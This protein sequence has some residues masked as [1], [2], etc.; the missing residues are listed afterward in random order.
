MNKQFANLSATLPCQ[1][2]QGRFSCCFNMYHSVYYFPLD[3]SVHLLWQRFLGKPHAKR[4]SCLYT[5]LKIWLII[6]TWTL[7]TLKS[8]EPTWIQGIW[9][10]E[11]YLTASAASNDFFWVGFGAMKPL[12]HLFRPGLALKWS[13]YRNECNPWQGTVEQ[14]L[15]QTLLVRIIRSVICKQ[16]KRAI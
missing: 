12:A 9:Q 1:L 5:L 14:H 7:V 11:K 4:G 6:F 13:S 10:S 8:T 2:S 3:H 16:R 15:T